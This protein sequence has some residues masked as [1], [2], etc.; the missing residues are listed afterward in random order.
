MTTIHPPKTSV[1]KRRL[2]DV[3]LTTSADKFTHSLESSDSTSENSFE[4]LARSKFVSHHPKAGINP[5]VDAAGY[6]FSIIG[7]LKRLAYYHHLNNLHNE[8]VHEIKNF[9]QVSKA[10]GYSSE[11]ILVSRYA[12]CAT[13][14]DIIM[15]TAW[16]N[17]NKWDSYSLL[18]A[19]N[20]ETNAHGRFF[21]L[22][23]Q[24][25]KS[26]NQYIDL[27][28]FMYICL[29]LG[30]KGGYRTPDVTN[31]QLDQICNVLYKHIRAYHGTFSKTLSPFPIRAIPRNTTPSKMISLSKTLFFTIIFVLA[32]FVS[33]AFILDIFSAKPYQELSHIR[34]LMQYEKTAL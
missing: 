30:F 18:K 16:G 9:E 17:Q 22:L 25:V 29:S 23:E 6:L 2:S 4:L 28:E 31:H 3:S 14:D 5:L 21:M 34:N 32:L 15:H 11:Y 7:K 24:I 8:L 10:Q 27:M 19:F 13:L 12:L 20:Q 1:D 33:L 26:P